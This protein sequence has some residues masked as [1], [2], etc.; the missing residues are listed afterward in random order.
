MGEIRVNMNDGI[1]HLMVIQQKGADLAGD[2]VTIS[3]RQ[4]RRHRYLDD[5]DIPC[6]HRQRG[7]GVDVM[8]LVNFQDVINQV[9]LNIL[10]YGRVHQHPQRS[11]EDARTAVGNP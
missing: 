6:A 3:H 5:E 10:A 7:N 8:N 11:D 9:L 2:G 4:L 1:S